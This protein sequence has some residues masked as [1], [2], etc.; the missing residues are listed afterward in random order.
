[1][2]KNING[3][4]HGGLNFNH[5]IEVD[6]LKKFNFNLDTSKPAIHLFFSDVENVNLPERANAFLKSLN[7]NYKKDDI[8]IF[9]TPYEGWYHMGEYLKNEI[10]NLYPNI[11]RENILYANEQQNTNDNLSFISIDSWLSNDLN[12]PTHNFKSKNKIFLSYNRVSRPHRC[13]LVAELRF[14]KL[15]NHGL[16]SFIP[17]YQFYGNVLNAQQVISN[18]TFL[19][20]D[21]KEIYKSLV[22][23]PMFIDKYDY[24]TNG[25]VETEW[26]GKTRIHY[27]NTILSLVTESHWYEEQISFTEKIFKPIAHSHPFIVVAPKHF[28]KYL[29]RVGF[30]T[31]DGIID[32]SYDNIDNHFNRLQAIVDE[33][34]KLCKLSEKELYY[35][36]LKLDE[37]AKYNYDFFQSREFRFKNSSLFNFLYEKSF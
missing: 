22:T 27:L 24:N 6:I 31:F 18:D 1:M 21:K 7:L 12:I 2:K 9:Y 4:L 13:Q 37:I 28:L 26:R 14:R 23:D 3:I 10:N 11:P 15:D 36:W 33:I 5:A 35:K 34:E 16:V 29:R 19:P 25:M 20:N 17:E 30:K 32:E 8:L